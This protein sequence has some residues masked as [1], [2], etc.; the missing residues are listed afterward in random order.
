MIEDIKKINNNLLYTVEYYDEYVITL[1]KYTLI[2]NLK[3]S[4]NQTT[5]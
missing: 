2:N 1:F 4:V 5:N 3:Q